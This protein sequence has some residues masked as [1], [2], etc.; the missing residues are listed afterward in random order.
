MLHAEEKIGG[1]KVKKT[2][3]VRLNQLGQVKDAT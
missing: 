1:G 2:E 3:R